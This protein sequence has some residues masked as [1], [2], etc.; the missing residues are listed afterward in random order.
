MLHIFSNVPVFST[1]VKTRGSYPKLNYLIYTQVAPFLSF[2]M[3][4]KFSFT[5]PRESLSTPSSQTVEPVTSLDKQTQSR[6]PVDEITTDMPRKTLPTQMTPK[7]KE[8]LQPRRTTTAKARPVVTLTQESQP[9]ATPT[10]Q[11]A[12]KTETTT[13]AQPEVTFTPAKLPEKQ[14][15]TDD[16]EGKTVF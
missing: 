16:T 9:S 14:P 13:T 10:V 2:Y 11:L 15:V 7:E 1:S 6:Q 3:F 8:I 12:L 4:F 5:V